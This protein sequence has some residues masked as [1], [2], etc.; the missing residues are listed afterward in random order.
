M[1]TLQPA[2]RTPQFAS[3]AEFYRTSPYAAFEQEHR[4]GGSF[5]VT[6]MEVQQGEIEII[7][8]PTAAVS[9]VSCF[10]G[11]GRAEFDF[12]SG[13]VARDLKPGFV[14]LQPAYQACGLRVPRLDLRNIYVP[15][16]RLLALLDE[17]GPSIPTLDC[18][19][20]EMRR[21]PRAHK[22]IE[23][24]WRALATDGPGASLFL[25]GGLMQL[26]GLLLDAAGDGRMLAPL[27]AI[28]DARLTRVI[29]YIETHYGEPLAVAEL[30]TIA[31][32]SPS[33]FS[34]CFKATTGESVWSY[35]QRRRCERVRELLIGS[36]ES[37]AQI[38][39]ACGFANQ[40]HLTSVFKKTFG[41]TPGEARRA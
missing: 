22:V 38:A 27:P 36:H 19:T 12:G 11:G 33:H 23:V 8:P 26:I 9:I 1:T 20:G 3:V 40:G 29:D 18:V 34:K 14:D 25:D 6:M 24:M 15:E 28:G 35:V 41:V 16:K 21:L 37:I 30:A 39:Y 4:T 7:D 31:A 13:W 2:D 10:G 5:G 17:A 32:M